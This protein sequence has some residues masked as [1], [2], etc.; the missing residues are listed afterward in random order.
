VRSARATTA[1]S[2]AALAAGAALAGCVT[3]QEKNARTLLTNARTLASE[4]PV[5]VG[6]E[7][8]AVR[9]LRVALITSKRGDA[10]VVVVRSS[11]R[12]PLTDLP[13][14]VG[15]KRIRAKPVYVNAAPN[16]DYYD[17][18][19]PLIPAGGAVT[20]V[21]P[22]VNREDAAGGP[23]F[24]AVGL[25]R[26]PASTNQTTLPQITASLRPL[27]GRLTVELSNDSGVPQYG[28]QV[29]ATALRHGRYV[30]AGREAVTELDAGNRATLTVPLVGTDTNATLALYAPPTIFK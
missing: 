7:N 15:V 30:A 1:A 22:S 13:I 27:A 4:T 10:V 29:Y 25:P 9:V 11:A 19:I 16:L 24:A 2:V 17:T 26:T 18:H 28:L 5:R 14:S 6:T 21:L 8:P 3:T 12:R 23:L 20:W